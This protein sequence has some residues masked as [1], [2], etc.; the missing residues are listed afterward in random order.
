MNLRTAVVFLLL[1]ARVSTGS[2]QARIEATLQGQV[3][4]STTGRPI[5]NVSVFLSG[6][7]YGASSG[8]DGRYAFRVFQTGTLQLIFSRVGYDVKVME[9]S[10]S[11]SAALVCNTILSPKVIPFNEVEVSAE[12]AAHWHQN[13]LDYNAQAEARTHR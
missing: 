3:S 7:T 6:S 13:Y 10:I 5:E 4:D 8:S 11:R 2:A 1:L 9:V 12:V